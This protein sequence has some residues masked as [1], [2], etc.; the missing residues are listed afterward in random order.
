[1]KN[2]VSTKCFNIGWYSGTWYS[3]SN[4]NQYDIICTGNITLTSTTNDI[5]HKFRMKFPLER[6]GWFEADDGGVDAYIVYSTDYN[7]YALVGDGVDY[8]DIFHR[9]GCRIDNERYIELISIGEYMGYTFDAIDIT[10]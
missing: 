10:K 1:M 7:T 6:I 8:I 2:L 9:P 4:E 3:L 5:D